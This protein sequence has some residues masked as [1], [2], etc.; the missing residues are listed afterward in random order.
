MFSA[1]ERSSIS[2]EI[3]E[4]ESRE[5]YLHTLEMLEQQYGRNDANLPTY[6]PFARG[7]LRALND[8]GTSDV[9]RC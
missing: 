9:L 2:T 3:I 4:S 7:V 5:V 6:V 1:P 8:G